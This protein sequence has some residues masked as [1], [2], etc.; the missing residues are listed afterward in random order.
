MLSLNFAQRVN[1]DIK[2]LPKIKVFLWPRWGHLR[3]SFDSTSA[4][5]SIL[6]SRPIR[7]SGNAMKANEN[8]IKDPLATKKWLE[9]YGADL[10]SKIFLL[11]KFLRNWH[12]S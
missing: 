6:P 10:F 12:L 7:L 2:S 3:F 9:K 11:S 4:D 1:L 5:S 8:K